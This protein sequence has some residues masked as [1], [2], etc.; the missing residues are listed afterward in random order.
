MP[1]VYQPNQN[2]SSSPASVP[3]SP[4]EAARGKIVANI[5]VEYARVD[6]KSLLLDLRTPAGPGPYRVIVWI[7]GGAWKRGDKRLGPY[8]PVFRQ[9]WRGYAVAS[10]NYQLS[11]EALFPAQIHDCKAAIRWLRGNAGRHKLNPERIAAWGSSAGGYLAALLGTT[12]GVAELED[13]SMGYANESSAVQA[14]VDWFG[15]TDFLKMGGSHNNPDSPE[16]LL[17]GCPIET[18]PELVKTANP[19]NYITEDDPPFIIQH[20]TDDRTVPINQ[21]ELLY[22]ALQNAGV[23]ATY[24]PLHGVGHRLSKFYQVDNIRHIEAFLDRS[25]GSSRDVGARLPAAE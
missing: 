20:G 17:L 2:A 4:H 13:F 3:G 15:P 18:C 25:V 5:N 6:G 23:P 16:S 21:S 12:G 9:L 14:V 7:H 1:M 10:I 22:S 24:L 8:H 19:I 11:H